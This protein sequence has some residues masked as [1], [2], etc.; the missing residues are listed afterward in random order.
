MISRSLK[1]LAKELNIPIVALSQLNR[2]VESRTDGK[3][4]QLSDLRE[5]GA[6]EQDADIVCFIHR[7]EY[8]LH[9][10]QREEQTELRGKA[11]FIIA[12]HRSGSVE[13]VPLRFR[14]RY[15]RFENWDEGDVHFGNATASSALNAY[16][17]DD[18][19][20]AAPALGGGSANITA[21]SAENPF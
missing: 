7:P 5:S 4:P 1:Q 20:G 18:P 15:A 11:E 12:K 16:A 8:Y 13:D 19:F 21:T 6:I 3:R 9:G 14:A 2:S 17:D 10:A